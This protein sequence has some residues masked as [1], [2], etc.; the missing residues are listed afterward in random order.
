MGK[1]SSIASFLVIICSLYHC[2]GRDNIPV[3]H[4]LPLG[5]HRSPEGRVTSVTHT[6]TPEAFFN[7]YVALSKPVLLKGAAKLS[8]GF[9]RWSDD[10]LR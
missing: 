5:F 3:G 2:S 4:L 1:S 10:Y 6:L 7:E 8:A 9:H